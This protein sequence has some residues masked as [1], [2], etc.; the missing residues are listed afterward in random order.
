MSNNDTVIINVNNNSF[1]TNKAE[2]YGGAIFNNVS[3]M[4]LLGNTM[5]SNTASILGNIIYN[6]GSMGILNL[7]YINNS[8]VNVTNGS[9]IVLY[10][11][12]TDDMGNPITGQN[13][14]FYVNGIN[15]ANIV[16]IEGYENTTYTV[17][18]SSGDN[19]P[20]NGYYDGIRDFDI[21]TKQSLLKMPLIKTNSTIIVLNGTV[22]KSVNISGIAEDE[23][24]DPLANVQ[25]NLT[26][27]G[28]VYSVS[29]N[30]LG[31]WNLSYIP[32]HNGNFGVQVS[33]ISD[34]TYLAFINSTTFS[35]VNNFIALNNTTPINNTP[36]NITG[37]P[38]LTLTRNALTTERV[39]NTL[40]FA[41]SYAYSNL[42]NKLGS[43]YFVIKFGK[44]YRLLGLKLPS[45]IIHEFNSKTNVLRVYIKNLKPGQNASVKFR[46]QRIMGR[47]IKSYK[48]I[49]LISKTFINTRSLDKAT[50]KKKFIYKN[51]NKVKISKSISAKLGSNKHYFVKTSSRASYTFNESKNMLKFLIKNLSYQ[52][53]AI[54]K[55]Y[56]SRNSKYKTKNLYFLWEISYF[57]HYLFFNKTYIFYN[58][59]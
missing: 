23:N 59:L 29:T 56:A 39:K 3:N 57:S 47:D 22:D 5:D 21:N 18:G 4:T 32:T 24:V 44:R 49:N 46:V 17:I 40:T 28:V 48:R 37:I 9:V 36:I 43:K 31:E 26:I 2:E 34:S 50:L 45:N 15:I 8:T 27:D 1:T 13:M 41:K 7:T 11:A 58:I 53:K 38:G 55:Y 52:Q 51:F 25:L 12:L 35:V 54:I 20:V 19:L 42:G 6:N 14:I 16:S 30:S 10:F 33:F